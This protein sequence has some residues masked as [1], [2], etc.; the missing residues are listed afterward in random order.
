[1]GMGLWRGRERRE[2]LGR[3]EG[4]DIGLRRWWFRVE[5][6][7]AVRCIMFAGGT[8]L[9]ALVP[10]FLWQ[11]YITTSFVPNSQSRKIKGKRA[12]ITCPA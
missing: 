5:V 7:M 2:I 8:K 11:E 9:A 12:E 1:M 6:E 4:K 3:V 10:Y